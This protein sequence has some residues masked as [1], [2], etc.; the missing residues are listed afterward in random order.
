MGSGEQGNNVIYVRG[1]GEHKSKNEGNR[2]TK[3]ILGSREHRKLRFCFGGTMKN[4]SGE[5]GNRYPL[6]WEG[7][8]K[9]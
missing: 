5:Q 7:L 2:R 9:A 6:P 1:T 4:I 3:V 8:F